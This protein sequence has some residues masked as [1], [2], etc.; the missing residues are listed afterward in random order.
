M[1]WETDK[2]DRGTLLNAECCMLLLSLLINVN[3]SC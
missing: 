3:S 2:Q 1:R